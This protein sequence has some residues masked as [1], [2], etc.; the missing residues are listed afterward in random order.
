MVFDWMPIG[1]KLLLA[2]SVWIV[3]KAGERIGR[4][5]I[6]GLDVTDALFR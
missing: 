2:L 3:L 6:G 1:T 5:A 4:F